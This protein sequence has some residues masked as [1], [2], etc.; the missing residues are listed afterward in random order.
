MHQRPVTNYPK[1]RAC[2]TYAN[3]TPYARSV[4]TFSQACTNRQHEKHTRVKYIHMTT[5]YSARGVY[6][7]AWLLTPV[8]KPNAMEIK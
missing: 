3:I 8:N 7:A 1:Q 6:R 2:L 4:V 5:D